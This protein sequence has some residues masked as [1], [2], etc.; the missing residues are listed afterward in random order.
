M[1]LLTVEK[2]KAYFK[3]LGLGDYN[4]A[5]IRAF[6]KKYLRK[7]DVDGIYGTDTDNLL[8]HVYNV[9]TFTK[10]FEP[11]EFKCECGGK[12][13]TGYPTYMK[14]VELQNLQAIRD[15][16]K[17][18]MKV[19]CGMRCK[20]YNNS[21]K[22]SITNSKHLTGYATDFYMKG[23][24]D[25]LANRKASIKWMKKLANT[26]YVYGNG[27]N[28]SGY[29]VSA[30]YMGNAVHYDTNKPITEAAKPAVTKTTKK[31]TNAE[32]LAKCAYDFAYTTNTSQAKYPSGSPREAYSKAIDKVYG[33]NRK[34]STPAKKGA[35]CDVFVG[36]C[37]RSAGIDKNFPRGLSP[38]YL[39]KSKM[40]KQVSK[41]S[42]KSG[43]IIV[44]PK[45]ICI[46]YNGKIKEASYNGFY[47][48]TT[49]SLKKRLNA[50]GAKVYRALDTAKKTTAS[51]PKWVTNAN[52]WAKKI[53]ADNTY[54]YVKWKSSDVKTHECPICHNHP[55]GYSHGWNCIGFTYAIWH[56]GGGL[57][58]KCNDGVI[59]NEVGD[60]MLQM[61]N[62]NALSTATSRIGIKEIKIII[63]KNGI[64]K[65][66]WKAGDICMMFSGNK[67]VH[68]FYYMGSG[69]IAEATG[70]SGKVPNNDQIRIKSYNNYSAKIIIRYI[71][72]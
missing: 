53:A 34:W 67:Y 70:S 47:P 42:V 49:D 13:C 26:N 72:K 44:S 43:D 33:K 48:K 27:Y 63:N 18:P 56:H 45:H 55:K 10:N 28:S 39:A 19:T 65:S 57:K 30:P 15:H 35:S 69:K 11:E 22:G 29:A 17:K 46:V 2:R 3:K 1:A 50:S 12:Y 40:F 41:N 60:K 21:L 37:V 71:G 38:S 31:L 61:S 66:Q 4:E 7:K 25:T 5:N 16:W 9:K 58:C 6:Q 24:T 52:A 64:P 14:K 8:R 23:V 20:P 51:T 32:K 68:N 62:A 59:S 36:T 54:H